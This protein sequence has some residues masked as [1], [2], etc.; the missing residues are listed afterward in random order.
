M[1]VA[2]LVAL[3]GPRVLKVPKALLQERGPI[4]F[5]RKEVGVEED[6]AFF[7]W[8]GFYP[9]PETCDG[10][11]L[12]SCVPFPSQ[13]PKEPFFHAYHYDSLTVRPGT[14]RLKNLKPA[15]SIR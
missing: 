1:A 7:P 3:L 12:K 14:H 15:A 8:L 6:T 10:A 5:L 9:D 13:C 11:G 2:R 4:V